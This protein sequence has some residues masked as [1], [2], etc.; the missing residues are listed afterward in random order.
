MLARRAF[1]RV[2]RPQPLARHL[3]VLVG[4]GSHSGTATFLADQ[5]ADDISSAGMQAK[6]VDQRE[7]T[8]D[9]ISKVRAQPVQLP[10]CR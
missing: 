8:L 4:W 10:R 5:L 1:A 7:I 6:A 3:N 9:T 2:A